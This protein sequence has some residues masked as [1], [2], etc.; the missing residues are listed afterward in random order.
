MN[1]IKIAV[2]SDHAGYERKLVVVKHL[3]NLGYEVKDFG[4]YSSESSD[5]ADWAHPMA[6]AV[7]NGE[8]P[9][10]ISLC[11]SGNGINMTVNKHQGIRSALCWNTE[12]AALAKQ[13]NNANILAIP[14]RFVTDDEATN[15]VD[16]FMNAEFEGGRH[17]VRIDKIPLK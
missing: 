6:S 8:F 3:E 16:A 14:A 1:K 15:I 7:E 2:A 17:Q 4:A 10:G 13:H 5:Y 11:G 12:I 9:M